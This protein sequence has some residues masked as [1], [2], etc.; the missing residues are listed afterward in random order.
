MTIKFDIVLDMNNITKPTYFEIIRALHRGGLSLW[1]N[2]K[3]L[4]PMTFIPTIITF[5]SL[6]IIRGGLPPEATPFL[7]A[8]VQIPADFVTGLFCALIIYIIVSAP[9][10]KDSE[11]P[12]V[13]SLNLKEKKSLFISAAIANVVFSYFVNGI[14]GLM[15]MIY[16]PLQAASEV[17][18]AT[19]SMGGMFALLGLLFVLFYGVRFILIPILLIAGQDIRG[20]YSR[21][22]QIGFSLPIFSLKLLTTFSIG[23]VVLLISA[24]LMAGGGEGNPIPTVQMGIID[25]L[26]AFGGVISTAWCYAALAIGYRQMVEGSS[27]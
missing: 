9:K 22:K 13:F 6:M 23:F 10:K 5:L 21:Y 12:V 16:A 1:L 26:T 24:P 2:R 25:F 14:Y 3:T 11:K 4:L 27:K 18:G 17:E 15:N 8:V 20:F 19:P 7:M